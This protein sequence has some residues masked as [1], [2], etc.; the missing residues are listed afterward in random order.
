MLRTY[1]QYIKDNPEGYWFKKKL[2]GWG[3]TPAT[4]KG[5]LVTIVY[6]ALVLGFALTIDESSPPRELFFTFWLP[7]ILLTI[8]FMRIAYVKGEGQVGSGELI[9]WKTKNSKSNTARF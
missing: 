4:W 3:W 6:L 9:I 2:Y 7:L 1:L 5:W 8:T